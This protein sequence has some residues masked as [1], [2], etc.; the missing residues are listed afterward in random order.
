MRL[1]QER[2]RDQGGARERD[3]EGERKGGW[4]VVWGAVLGDQLG[5]L[6]ISFSVPP[7]SLHPTPHTSQSNWTKTVI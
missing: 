1:P 6:F 4:I 5:D 2:G 7:F 3:G